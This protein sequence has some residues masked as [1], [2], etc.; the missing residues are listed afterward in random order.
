MNFEDFSRYF[1][2]LGKG[3]KN[4][5]SEVLKNGFYRVSLSHFFFKD[6][7]KLDNKTLKRDQGSNN[8]I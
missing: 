8:C 2:I 4:S 5:L 7:P 6:F 3:K 1:A